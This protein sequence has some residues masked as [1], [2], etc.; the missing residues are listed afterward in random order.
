MWMLPKGVFLS[1]HIVKELLECPNVVRN[2]GHHRGHRAVATTLAAPIGIP[3]PPAEVEV[4]HQDGRAC[5][6]VF[7]FL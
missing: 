4:S 2:A 3:S 5:G 1:H 6:E 7:E